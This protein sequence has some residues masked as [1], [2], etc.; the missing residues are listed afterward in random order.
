[1]ITYPN[2]HHLKY[3]VDAVALG[4]ISG[5]AQ[6][7]LVTH[8]AISRSISALDRH[9]GVSLLEHQ[10][11]SF[12]L[13]EAGYKVA[14]QAQLL[15]SA[16][17][18]FG[19]LSL[20]KKNSEGGELKIGVSRTL[21]EAYLHP[22]LQSVKTQFPRVTTKVRFGTTNQIIEAVQDRSIEVGLS[23][24]TLNLATLKQTVVKRGQFVLVEAGSK[25]NWSHD[26]NSKSFLVTEARLETEK[27]KVSY[28]RQ[29]CRPLPVQ[30]E[31]SSWDVIAQLVQQGLGIGLLPDVSVKNWKKGSF[32]VLNSFDFKFPY[33][34]FLH[35][36]KSSESNRVLDCVTDVIYSLSRARK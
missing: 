4:S 27:L 26:I 18:D 16:A 9:L 24:G 20:K 12:K 8:P 33:E 15:L 23:I 36:L 35:R 19:S 30:F 25:R 22:I 34:I 31:V 5:A 13:T 11:K 14:E 3:F 1:M 6:K 32:R 17:S 28:K 29:F 2:L 10:K 7:N 21:S